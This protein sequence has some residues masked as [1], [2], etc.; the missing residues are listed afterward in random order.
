MLY[1][2]F[3]IIINILVFSASLE[4]L[5]Y[6]STWSKDHYKFIYSYS[7]GIDFGRQNVTSPDVRF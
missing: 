4:Y 3:E 6:W 1:F 2:H 5:C 7:A